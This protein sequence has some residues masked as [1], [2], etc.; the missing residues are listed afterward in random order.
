MFL[1]S[2]KSNF[3]IDFLDF[4]YTFFKLLTSSHFIPY[5]NFYAISIFSII[6]YV[7]TKIIS[8]RYFHPFAQLNPLPTIIIVSTT[9]NT[10]TSRFIRLNKFFFTFI[11]H[12]PKK[13]PIYQPSY[14]FYIPH[15]RLLK[16]Y[17][18]IHQIFPPICST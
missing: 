17:H 8:I 10:N 3:I 12:Q 7:I 15:K 2:N 6:S 16:K 9:T 4:S 13:C 1:F 14:H 5:T 18:K 11:I